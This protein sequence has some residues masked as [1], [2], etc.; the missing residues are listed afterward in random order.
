MVMQTVVNVTK[1]EAVEAFFRL[2]GQD[3]L[4]ETQEFHYKFEAP[5]Q[6]DVTEF[7]ELYTQ[8]INSTLSTS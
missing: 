5:S 4:R 1:L 3:L 7:N 6:T 2:H 8:A